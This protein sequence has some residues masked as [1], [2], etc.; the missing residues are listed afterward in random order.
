MKIVDLLDLEIDRSSQTIDAKVETIDGT[1]SSRSII[2]VDR[3]NFLSGQRS[4]MTAA[5]CR[6]K[7][8]STKVCS[9]YL[10]VCLQTDSLDS[11]S[12]DMMASTK[13]RP[14]IVHDITSESENVLSNALY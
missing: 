3:A 13:Q 4:F 10:T 7:S 8:R 14:A 6:S 12:C 11:Y 1:D 5:K 9:L 2:R